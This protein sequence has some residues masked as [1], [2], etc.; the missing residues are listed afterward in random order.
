LVLPE[1]PEELA[2]REA[3]AQAQKLTDEVRILFYIPAFEGSERYPKRRSAVEPLQVV[4]SLLSKA[5]ISALDASES[6]LKV[7]V[8]YYRTF[9]V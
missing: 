5:G 4:V 3:Y 7:T 6:Y 9:H 2:A 1:Y 8:H